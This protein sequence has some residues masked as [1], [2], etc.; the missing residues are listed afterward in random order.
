MARQ[1]QNEELV[2]VLL[3]RF[4]DIHVCYVWMSVLQIKE[5]MTM[6]L[7]VTTVGSH[8]FEKTCTTQKYTA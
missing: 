2:L 5:L 3:L 1:L 4:R 7:T 8:R 6:H